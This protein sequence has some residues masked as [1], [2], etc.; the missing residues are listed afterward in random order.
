VSSLREQVKTP[1]TLQHISTST[2]YD[3]PY[4]SRLCVNIAAHIDH[5][6][7]TEQ[8]QL[9]NEF[10]V[11]PLARWINNDDCFIWWQLLHDGEYGL[12]LSSAK[13]TFVRGDIIEGD[14]VPSG[15]DRLLRVDGT[16]Q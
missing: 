8:E 5:R 4:I 6:A 2:P 12:G 3:L 13:D 7:G 9:L 14:I 10:V 1:Q 11:T 16:H 15:A